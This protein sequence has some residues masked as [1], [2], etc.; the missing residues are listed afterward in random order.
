MEVTFDGGND[1]RLSNNYGNR[2]YACPNKI[3]TPSFPLE[4]CGPDSHR[5]QWKLMTTAY[6][7]EPQKR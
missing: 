3:P 4:K 2:I 7:R 6:E 5:F 1:S